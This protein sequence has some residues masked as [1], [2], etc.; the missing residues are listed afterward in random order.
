MCDCWNVDPTKR[1]SFCQIS[2]R[3]YELIVLEEARARR[4]CTFS[5][6]PDSVYVKD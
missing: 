6:I 2:E 4:Y 3:I 1:P 5:I